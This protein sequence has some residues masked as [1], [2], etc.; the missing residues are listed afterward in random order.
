[1]LAMVTIANRDCAGIAKL[2]AAE[3]PAGQVVR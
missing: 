3:S 2:G 1:V